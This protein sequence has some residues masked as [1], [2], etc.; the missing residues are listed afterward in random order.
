MNKRHKE[1][2]EKIE[3]DEVTEQEFMDALGILLKPKT[4]VK[5]ENREPTRQDLETRYKLIR[6]GE[7]Q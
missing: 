1:E 5:F 7:T 4:K 6:T 3:R 2:F